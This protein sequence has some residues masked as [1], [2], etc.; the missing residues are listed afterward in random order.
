MRDKHL[1]L[2][3]WILSEECVF[4]TIENYRENNYDGATEISINSGSIFT[5]FPSP[6]WFWGNRGT[7]YCKCG[8][9]NFSNF[10]SYNSAMIQRISIKRWLLV[11]IDMETERRCYRWNVSNNISKLHTNPWIEASG[12]ACGFDYGGYNLKLFFLF[13]NYNFHINIF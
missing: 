9:G 6:C 2:L 12:F 8:M 3:C 5:W 10:K 7:N 1:N 4:E 13:W 11:G